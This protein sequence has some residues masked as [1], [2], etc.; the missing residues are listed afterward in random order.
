MEIRP[1]AIPG[2]KVLVPE[3]HVDARGFFVEAYNKRALAGAGILLEFVQDN[4]VYSAVAGTLRGLHFQKPPAAQ[5]KL[6]RVVRGRI[7]DVVV[8]LRR[9]SPSYGRHLALEL[10]AAA[11]EQLFCPHG[12]AHGYL[13]LEPEV[14][15]IYKVDAHFAPASATG[16]RF[17]DPDL[18]IA[19]PLR[20]EQLVLS[21]SDRQLPRWRE[22]EPVWD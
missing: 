20:P 13:T 5:A 12:L 9:G 1:T 18:A 8:D 15:V 10:S 4:H 16:V 7:L 22:L 14:E 6:L 19:W 11:G 2:V 17:D 3:R 21:E